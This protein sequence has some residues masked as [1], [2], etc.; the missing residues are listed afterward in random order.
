MDRETIRHLLLEHLKTVENKPNTQISDLFTGVATQAVMQKLVD[1]PAGYVPG[2]NANLQ[3]DHMSE[4][5]RLVVQELIWELIIQGIITPGSDWS[6]MNLPFFRITEYG[7]RCLQENTILPHDYGTYIQAIKAVGA[8]TDAIFLLYLGES[9]EAFNKALYISSVVNLGVASERLI[10]LLIDALHDAL[11]SQAN[12]TRFD[13][14]I[15]AG[16]HISKQFDEVYSRLAGHKAQLPKN[17][18]DDLEMLK[19]LVDIIRKERNDGG[20]PTG[21]QFSREETLALLLAFQPHYKFVIKV[22]EWLQANPNSL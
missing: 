4:A 13:Q 21:R 2:G 9:V 19:I 18:A 6:N 7:A 11:A 17:I 14:A 22:L 15:K 10:I 1:P 12:K 5:D 16:H 20:H 8:T 3:P